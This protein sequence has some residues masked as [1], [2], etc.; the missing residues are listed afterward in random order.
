MRRL[1]N[2]LIILFLLLV[3][4]SN[5]RA[6]SCLPYSS[7]LWTIWANSQGC[8]MPYRHL[9]LSKITDEIDGYGIRINIL[10]QYNCTAPDTLTDTVKIWGDPGWTCRSSP[11]STYVRNDSA[12]YYQIGDTVIFL[13]VEL[14]QEWGVQTQYES[15]NDFALSCDFSSVYVHDDSVFGGSFIATSLQMPLSQ[16]LDSVN[17]LW[18]STSSVPILTNPESLTLYPNP[19]QHDITIRAS[20]SWQGKMRFHVLDMSGRLVQSQELEFE[21]NEAQIHAELAP[22]IYAAQLVDEKNGRV[23][24][25]KLIITQ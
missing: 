9:V 4:M 18:D 2:A 21:N 6:C 25:E 22:G 23:Q 12:S 19:A 20:A 3:G 17:T 10:H 11:I 8:H 7:I 15:T 13:L 14:S 16:F 24:T 1:K 5:A